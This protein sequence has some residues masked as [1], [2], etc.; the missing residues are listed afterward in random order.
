MSRPMPGRRAGDERDMPG[1][2]GR[3]R[4][5]RELV[6]LERPVLE[7]VHLGVVEPARAAEA[8]ERRGDRGVRVR[9]DLEPH[10]ARPRESG[11][12]GDDAEAGNEA[13]PS[14]QRRARPG[15]AR[16][17]RSTSTC[18]RTAERPPIRS[19][20]SGVLAHRGEPVDVGPIGEAALGRGRRPSTT[21]RSR[22][23]PAAQPDEERAR[24]ASPGSGTRHRAGSEVLRRARDELE[25]QAVRLLV[26]VAPGDEP[27]MGEHDRARIRELG[28]PARELEAGPQVVDD[29]DVR[30]EGIAHGRVR[31]GRVRERADRVGVDVVDVRRGQERVQERLDRRARRIGL[32][33][34][35]REVGDHLLVGHRVTLAERQQLVEPEAREVGRR[36]R[37]EVGA[38]ALDPDHAPLATEVVASRRASSRCCRRRAGRACG[39]RRSAANG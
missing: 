26:R 20:W 27:V 21:R 28:D 17:E 34:A 25:R 29:R 33:E 38:A 32:D 1:E 22:R 15:S 6:E 13:R 23:E 24:P 30:A 10:A 14:G 9:R 18:R 31:V 35:A 16:H 4:R 8:V 36:D 12:R 7:V 3:R 39:R 19:M 37:R 11:R 2:L 5:E